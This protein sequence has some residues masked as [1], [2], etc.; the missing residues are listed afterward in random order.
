VHAGGLTVAFDRLL[1][2]ELVD[3][4]AGAAHA[5]AI[6]L[7]RATGMLS[8]GPMRTRPLPAGPEI[9]LDGAQVQGRHAV[10]YVLACGDVD[11]YV[12]A[13]DGFVPLLVTTGAGGTPSTGQAL[14]VTGAEVS[15]VRRGEGGGVEVRVFN[16]SATTAVVGLGGR[17]GWLIDLRGRPSALVDG[18]F[19]LGP[20]KI[21]TI[22]LTDDTA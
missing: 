19:D 7:L 22:A 8:R 16:P 6:T 9:E 1:E 18:A 15:S 5:L 17:R 2:Y 10:R 13:D 4:R 12:L 14:D 21:A 3:I 20:W 11:P